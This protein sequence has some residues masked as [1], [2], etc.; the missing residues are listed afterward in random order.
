MVR[1]ETL[2]GQWGDIRGRIKDIWSD[3][4]E[5]ELDKIAGRRDR[6][7]S[8]LQDKYN[9]SSQR[10]EQ[11]VDRLLSGIGDRTMDTVDDLN[12]LVS[13]YPWAV[14]VLAFIIGLV[15]GSMFLN[16]NRD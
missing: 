14:A 12:R 11:E 10:A 8:T 13:D 6:L 1:S 5:S 15:I 16:P 9:Y 4:T 3:F 7:V 2:E